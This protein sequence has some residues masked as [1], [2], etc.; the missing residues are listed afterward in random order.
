MTSVFGHGGYHERMAYLTAEV[1]KNP[2]DPLLYFELGNLHGEHGDLELALQNLER[3]DAL[4]PGKFVTDLARGNACLVAGKF[5]RAK[6][7]LDRQ[8]VTHPENPRAWLLRARAERQLG[9]DEA[10]L[11][12]FREALKRTPSLDPDIVQEVAD[13]LAMRGHRE[14]AAQVLATGIEKLGKIPSL[15]L[16]ALDLEIA[17]KNLDA[18]FRR[19]EEARRDAPRP[20]PWMARRAIVLAQVGRIDES[21]AAWKALADHLN[22]LPERERASAA[23]TNFAEESRQALAS[24]EPLSAAEQ[25]SS[26]NPTSLGK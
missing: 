14:E 11:A 24:L 17:M 18:A 22:S 4:A 9:Q 1:E 26:S 23:M 6:E 20:E 10:S 8:L 2:D 15:V 25:S 7:A 3:V 13:A 5:T 12:D 21:R 19:I 16:R